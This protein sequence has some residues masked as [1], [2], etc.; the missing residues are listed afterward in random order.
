MPC[1]WDT[2]QYNTILP[3]VTVY[4]SNTLGTLGE[5][6]KPTYNSLR[7]SS[8]LQGLQVKGSSMPVNGAEETRHGNELSVPPAESRLSKSADTPSTLAQIPCIIQCCS[9]HMD[10]AAAQQRASGH[11]L[12]L[13]NH[14]PGLVILPQENIKWK[15]KAPMTHIY[16][17]Y[18][19]WASVA[20]RRGISL[21]DHLPNLSHQRAKHESLAWIADNKWVFYSEAQ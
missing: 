13:W 16:T 8:K 4:R 5:Q 10:V 12:V 11:R 20:D 15:S 14:M 21:S 2:I 17:E 6:K 7:L 9:S 3:E 1:T 19:V 18:I